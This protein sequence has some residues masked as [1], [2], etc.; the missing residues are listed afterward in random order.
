MPTE[1]IGRYEVESVIGRGAMAVVYRAVDPTIGRTVAL[2]TMRFD[3][4]GIEK[5]EVLS[6]FRN[7]A[8]AAGKLLHPNLVT[9]YDAGEQEGTFYIAMECV[10]G[11]TLQALLAEQ[12]FLTLDR[13]VDVM[14]QICAGLDYAHAN[15][16]IHRD[17][18]PANI[19][20]TRGGVIKIMDFGIAKSGAQLTTGGDVLGTPNYIS[21]EMVKGD[22]IDGRSD[23]F[24]VAVILHEML[25]GERPFTAPNISTI[26][27]KIVNEPLSPELETKVHPALAAILRKSLAKH[28]SD[29]YQS[30]VDLVGALKSYQALL[31]QPIPNTVVP[32]TP[33]VTNWPSATPSAAAVAPAMADSTPKSADPFSSGFEIPEVFGSD[34]PAEF[35]TITTPPRPENKGNGNFPP[36]DFQAP[37]STTRAATP[38]LPPAAASQRPAAPTA[39]EAYG[40]QAA[41]ASLAAATAPAPTKNRIPRVVLVAGITAVVIAGAIIGYKLLPQKAEPR[42]G[43]TVPAPDPVAITQ[44]E[45]VKNPAEHTAPVAVVEPGTEAEG[46]ATKPAAV[47]SAVPSRKRGARPESRPA[48]VAATPTPAPVTTADLAITST[49]DGATVQLDG[50]NRSEKT[51]FTASGL[52][53]GSH[54]LILTKPGYVPATRTIEIAAGNN[55]SLSVNLAVAFTG[56]AFESTPSGAAIFVD[57]EPTGQST[58]ATIKFSPGT[59]TISIYRPG[60]D[61]GTGTVHLDQGETQHF[62][63]VLQAGDR[64]ARIHRVFAGAKDKAMIVVRSRP[65]GARITL[66]DTSVDATTPA[67]LIVKNGKVRLTVEKDGYKPFHREF[68]VEKSDIVVIDATLEPKQ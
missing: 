67:R 20:I 63:V 9:I 54:M 52:K 53:P 68:K 65:R 1:I 46:S 3:V 18:K 34:V 56:I 62:S 57:E 32:G 44:T 23:L 27:Y 24:S 61:E 39:P 25:L 19:M 13:T 16:V 60:F 66:D 14:A 33:I 37:G 2:K 26:I 36:L 11:S 42:A 15:G 17:I 50:E 30:G 41:E 64:E 35:R 55:A 43:L 58:P 40:V 45:S 47:A 48:P 38:N 21:P 6:R 12:R 49:P 51:P 28:P 8:R 59:H 22:P 4:H 31:T 5:T 29:R 7:E 10:E